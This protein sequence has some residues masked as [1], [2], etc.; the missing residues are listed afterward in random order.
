VAV[1]DDAAAPPGGIRARLRPYV[2]V[3]HA[4]HRRAHGDDTG[5]AWRAA[6]TAMDEAGIVFVGAYARWRAAEA[7]LR[8]GDRAS[9][10]SFA[11]EASAVASALGAR[12]LLDEV[13]ALMRRA[14]LMAPVA[15]AAGHTGQFGLSPRE[16]EVL[17]LVADGCSNRQIADKLFISPKTASVHVSN[18]LGKL[19]VSTRGEAAA[20][21]HRAGLVDPSA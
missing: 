13:S 15:A 9:A 12:P 21:A 4:E 11:A 5:D 1:L 17:A 10:A 20:L 7:S 19:G 14:R 8:E 2:A 16:R 18:I 3:C 6:V